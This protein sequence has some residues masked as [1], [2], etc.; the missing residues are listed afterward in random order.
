MP[1]ETLADVFAD[2]ATTRGDFLVYDDG[3]R[4]R[5]RTYADVGRAARATAARLARAGLHKGDRMLLWGENSPEWIAAFW[6]A[7]IA[8]VVVVP[9]DYRS[10]L[11]FVRRIRRIVDA[12]LVLVGR[13]VARIEAHE[14]DDPGTMDGAQVWR[15]AD[16]DWHAAAEPPRVDLAGHDTA[17]ILFT[18]GATAE[19]KG[20]VLT[21]RNILANINP[22][23]RGLARYRAYFRPV[24]PFRF[25][26]L[27]PLSHMFGQAMT[28]FVP[29]M[30]A[31]T[32]IFMRSY[33]P[34]DIIGLIR[35]RRV[36]VLVSVP[37]MLDVLREHVTR[38]APSIARPVRPGVHWARRWWH[39]RDVHRLFGPKFWSCVV[40]AAPLDPALEAF[41]S[42]LGFL[43]V[44]GYGLTET[45][46][47]V[48]L[49]HPLAAHRGSVGKPLAGLDV[50]L[51]QDGE[52]LVRGESVTSG[53]FNAPGATAAAFE[54]GWLRTGDIG[55]LDDEGRLYVRGRKKEVIVRPDGLNVFPDDV[56]RVLDAVPGVRE[57]AVV[58]V[59]DGVGE[60]V[61]AVLVVEPGV[62]ADH[63]VARANATLAEHQRVRTVLVW[64]AGPLPRTEG[65][66]KLKRVEIKEWARSGHRTASAAAS[67]DP[68][69]DLLAR[70]APGRSVVPA[71]RIDDLGLSSLDRIELMMAI[72]QQFRTSVDE[73]AFSQARDLGDLRT[74]VEQAPAAA[75][76]ARE[77][78]SFPSWNR[79]LVA[80][81]VR[82]IVLDV[83]VLPLTR[84]FARLR[85]EGV[86]H[87]TGVDGPVVFASNHQSHMDTAVVLA[88]LPARWRYRV[89]PAMRKEFF[90][91]HFFPANVGWRERWASSALYYL[92]A[93]CFNGF[94]LPQR[95]A[96][97]R[98]TLR[99]IGE[100]A[101][102]GQSVLLFPEGERAE[103]GSIKVFRGGVGMIGSRL[104]LPVVAVRLD[105]VDR[106]LPASS[107]MAR[108]GP[109][110]VRFG[111]PVT[112][113]GD[114]YAGLARTV[115]AAVRN[116]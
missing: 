104:G 2:L 30:L 45:A 54:D 40:G 116:L 8:G 39:H 108:R 46:P 92:A 96:G 93:L 91:A 10:S 80:R 99:Y 25:L 87:L 18:S 14:T 22:V 102:A 103:T 43:V 13:D 56:E 3:Y 16:M 110:R 41:W 106:V 57:S 26:N 51:S 72:E 23:E 111:P 83:L 17:E 6:G 11:E 85:I 86:E 98:D 42:N 5:V 55:N 81:V 9:V 34:A 60:R 29:P 58:G 44:Q 61:T 71:T 47:I 88:A 50:K 70:F 76:G 77:S 24:A 49:N 35:R 7:I 82:R 68:L 31:G 69:E 74:L 48:A 75:D 63:V 20:V 100:L 66:R 112:L 21:H 73:V 32:T 52:I 65:T 89:A 28:T 78:V 115:E 19:P 97:A 107:H 27:L 84:W 15:L 114:D 4:T 64:T 59:D 113:R 95:E 37:K 79:S 105:G 101:A 67:G 94:P 90:A 62:A 38:V 53:Y 1:R 109:V 36:S 12:P 33:N